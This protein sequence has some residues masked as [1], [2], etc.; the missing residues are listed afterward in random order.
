LQ[1]FSS[2]EHLR[3]WLLAHLPVSAPSYG[4]VSGTE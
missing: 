2:L 1:T 3:R 4:P